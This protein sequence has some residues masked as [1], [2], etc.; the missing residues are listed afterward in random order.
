MQP[1]PW[2]THKHTYNYLKL[3]QCL[4][5]VYACWQTKARQGKAECW[6]AKFTQRI[7][8]D[9]YM[10]YN[11]QQTQAQRLHIRLL[12]SPLCVFVQA[13]SS[14]QSMHKRIARQ[15]QQH[16]HSRHERKQLNNNSKCNNCV[17]QCKR[18]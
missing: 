15:Q 11:K 2:H 8:V 1:F 17:A 7:Q 13:E 6:L 3:Q 16:T 14:M 9:F 10:S 18:Y 5:Y 4:L 12:P